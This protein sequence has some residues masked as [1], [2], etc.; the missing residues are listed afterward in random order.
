[1]YDP[2]FEKAVQQKMEEL[3]FRPSESVWVNIEHAVSGRRRRRAVPFFWRVL[4][5]GML[6]TVAVGAYYFGERAGKKAIAPVIAK[7]NVSTAVVMEQPASAPKGIGMALAPKGRRTVPGGTGPVPGVA[8][9]GGGSGE[10]K[11]SAGKPASR[12]GVKELP[13]GQ[14]EHQEG[15][16]PSEGWQNAQTAA[17]TPRIG[18]YFYLPRLEDPR[19]TPRVSGFLPTAKKNIVNLHTLS[20]IRRPWEAGFVGGAGIDR[21]HRLDASQANAAALFNPNPPP[22]VKN[23]VSDVRLG[24]SFYAGVYLQKAVSDRWDFNLGMDL[25]YYSSRISIG[26]QV[27]TFVPSFASYIS[28]TALTAAPAPLVYTA[29]NQQTYINR[30]YLLELPVAMQYRINRSRMLPLF[31]EGG[32][33]VSR[34][35]GANAI[36]YDPSTGLYVKNENVLNK[37]QFNLSSALLIGVPFHGIRIQAGPQVQYGLTPLVNNPGF[38]DQHFFYT[39][40]RLVVLPGRK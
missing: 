37:T 25:H 2:K 1:M 9:E 11:G 29:G 28:Q 32:F 17:R 39:G 13:N 35:M 24:T 5:P 40:I 12:I 36:F 4:L 14:E 6:L 15:E 21:L 31:L 19:V 34:L 38:G 26:Q 33:S 23:S 8:G 10:G 18:A 22:S 30:Y 7:G 3:E 16:T 20:R 27:S